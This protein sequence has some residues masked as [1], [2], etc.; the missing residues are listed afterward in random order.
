MGEGKR[1]LPWRDC[2]AEAGSPSGCFNGWDGPWLAR[3]QLTSCLQEEA[4]PAAPSAPC[5]PW[6]SSE[7]FRQPTH[8]AYE[9]AMWQKGH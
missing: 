2:L 1:I 7:H 4:L 5:W 6:S 9:F 3:S 8:P